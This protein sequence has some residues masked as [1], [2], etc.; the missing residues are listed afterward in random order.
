[1]SIIRLE[2]V[3]RLYGF[4]DATAVALDD[5]SLEIEP[6]E[7]V[8][9]MGPSGSGKSTLMNILGLLDRPTHGTYQLHDRAVA[10]LRANQ[11]AKVRRDM[12][13]FVFQSFNLLPRLLF[14]E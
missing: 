10:R 13:G 5:V 1:M 14:I 11:R 8:A 3:S 4:G 9:V 2:H 6:G 12:V 7:F